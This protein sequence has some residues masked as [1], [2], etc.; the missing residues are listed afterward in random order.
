MKIETGVQIVKDGKAWGTVYTDG[1][2]TAY[3]WVAPEDAPIHNPAHLTK[4]TDVTYECSP[5]VEELR[6]AKIVKVE[7]ITRVIFL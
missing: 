6:T 7:R 5:Y 2:S 1:H 4:P 3:G